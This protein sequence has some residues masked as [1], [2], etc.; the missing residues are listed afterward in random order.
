M[1]DYPKCPNCG[2][3]NT[4]LSKNTQE[5]VGWANIGEFAIGFGAG[6]LGLGDYVQ[7]VN[8]TNNI[9]AELKCNNCGFVWP[10]DDIN[11]AVTRVWIDKDVEI[12]SEIGVLIHANFEVN[13]MLNKQGVCQAFFYDVDGRSLNDTNDK[14]CSE[15]GSVTCG[16][17]FQPQYE[18]TIYNDFKLFIPYME[19]HLNR[20]SLVKCDVYISDGNCW[21]AKS[22]QVEFEYNYTQQIN[23]D[24]E[25]EYVSMLKECLS[26]GIVSERE[27]RLLDKLRDKLGLSVYRAKELENALVK[28]LLS[29]EEAEYL[30]EYNAVSK[31]GQVSENERRLLDKLR[32]M[33]G[34]SYERAK[35]LE[36]K[37]LK[38][39][40]NN[41]EQLMIRSNNSEEDWI[42]NNN[43]ASPLE[44]V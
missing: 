4:D 26:N 19:L 40:T 25:R 20:P 42:P 15:D 41:K 14:F 38:E 22:L 35:E 12:E 6:M 24:V 39:T 32:V 27:R 29:S 33:L 31:D 7:D 44:Y 1:S 16:D 28:P 37:A 43:T 36:E 18:S 17:Y 9:N 34:L 13:G 3:S 10:Y 23:V 8:L 21:L 11:A 30:E 5:K 2:S